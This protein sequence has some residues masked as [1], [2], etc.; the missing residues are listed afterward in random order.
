MINV[1]EAKT[2]LSKL[3]E[4]VEAGEEIVIARAGTP[5]ARLVPHSPARTRRQ[6]GSLEGKIWMADDWDSDE[7]NEE[8]ARL[9]YGEDDEG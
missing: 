7:T 3:L 8:I 9:F 2:N 6:L 5:V 4:R 1:H